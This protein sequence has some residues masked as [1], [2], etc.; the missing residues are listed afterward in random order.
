MG[1]RKSTVSL[2]PAVHT[3]E[4]YCTQHDGAAS[5][6]AGPPSASDP[7]GGPPGLGC[8]GLRSNRKRGTCSRRPGELTAATAGGVHSGKQGGG[9]GWRTQQQL[10][11]QWPRSVH[12]AARPPPHGSWWQAS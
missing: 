8:Y 3:K 6:S 9:K 5:A 12:M 11:Q 2:R 1:G 10:Q 4:N 7:R